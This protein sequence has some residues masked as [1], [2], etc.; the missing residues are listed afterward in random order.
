MLTWVNFLELLVLT[1]VIQRW[2]ESGTEGRGAREVGTGL[3]LFFSQS[4]MMGRDIL[5]EVFSCD[6]VKCQPPHKG[7]INHVRITC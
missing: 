3:C 2:S 7:N 6:S 4:P 1:S 5:R